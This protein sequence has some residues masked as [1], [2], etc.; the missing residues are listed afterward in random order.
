M[1]RQ[2]IN[3]QKRVAYINLKK[4]LLTDN[5]TI[6]D[7]TYIVDYYNYKPWR[8]YSQKNTIRLK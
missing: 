7:S 1:F 8:Y 3:S 6:C 2:K 5:F 4:T